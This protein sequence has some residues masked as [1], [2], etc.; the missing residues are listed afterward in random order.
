MNP[1]SFLDLPITV[2]E[3][4]Y[5]ELLVPPAA[6]EGQY[7]FRPNDVSTSLLYTNRQVYAESR[8]IFY[9][10]NLFIIVRPDYDVFRLLSLKPPTRI[11]YPCLTVDNLSQIA[12]HG[13]FAMSMELLT[14]GSRPGKFP[15]FLRAAFVITAQALRYFMHDLAAALSRPTQVS[16][17]QFQ[18]HNIFRYSRLRFSE[19]VFGSVMSI[20]RLP[21]FKALSIRGPL[22]P[23][24]HQ[25]LMAKLLN[26]QDRI[27]YEF[28]GAYASYRSCIRNNMFPACVKSDLD[29]QW[30]FANLRCLLQ[31]LD[32]V[33]DF[34][35]STGFQHN[36]YY[37]KASLFESVADLYSKL[38]LAYL[39][40]AKRH[41]DQAVSSYLAARRV[42]EEGIA[43][44]TEDNRLVNRL[45]FENFPSYVKE[46]NMNLTGRAKAV[47]SLKASKAC[48]KLRDGAAAS[49]YISDARRQ[50]ANISPD[51]VEL[52][53]RLK[54]KNLPHSS[55][56]SDE[57]PGQLVRWNE[58]PRHD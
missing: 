6:R 34:H 28:A 27:W 1:K 3:Q 58:Q 39:I 38:V 8:D 25:Q 47:L 16:I 11:H 2:R 23:D 19:L 12:S 37:A 30:N 52:R 18:I 32:I 13:R 49:H 10:K 4:I 7:L 21:A 44:L 20:P 15:W 50:D 46:E 9:A 45:T 31:A 54:W 24:Y 35:A 43:Y 5:T 48:T 57:S 56:L 53:L 33:W 14:I 26:D 17:G 41:P 55:G 51:M 42:A 22:H 40:E 29:M 36:E